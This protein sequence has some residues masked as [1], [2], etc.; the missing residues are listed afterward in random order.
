MNKRSGTCCAAVGCLHSQGSNPSLSLYAFP[1]QK[2][3]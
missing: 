2:E 1:K 3:R